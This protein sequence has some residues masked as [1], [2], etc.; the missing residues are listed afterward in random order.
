MDYYIKQL[1]HGR[2]YGTKPVPISLPD[3]Q[4]D[5]IEP[6]AY[7][8]QMIKIPIPRFAMEGKS[9]ESMGEAGKTIVDTMRFVMPATLNFGNTTALRVQDIL[10]F[11]IVRSSKWERPIYFAI[12]SGGD[13][14]KIGLRDY[15]E[16][17]GMAYKLVPQQRQAY[18]A[19]VNEERTRAHF[20]TDIK[21]PSKEQAYGCLWRGLGDSSITF[22]E[23]QRRMISSYRQ[24]FYTLAMYLSNV[25]NKPEEMSAVLDRM[26]QVVPRKIHPIDFRLKADIAMFYGLAG[27]KVRQK[28][29]LTEIVQELNQQPASSTAEAFSQYHPMAVLLQA[30]QGLEEYDKALEQVQTIQRTFST[31]PG[32]AEFVNAKR[33]EIESLKKPRSTPAPSPAHKQQDKK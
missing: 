31:V 8:A 2:P 30:Y 20:F 29:Y 22:D 14:S 12:T 15:L 23:N 13:D 10:V 9:P 18:W 28:E 25:K 27:N 32:I 4:I 21:Q 26:E 16:L 1:K 3:D 24:P 7:Q 6:M 11:D 5:G 19:A 33:E 17:E